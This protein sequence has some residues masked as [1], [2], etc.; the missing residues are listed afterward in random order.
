LFDVEALLEIAKQAAEAAAA[1]HRR[2]V[3]DRLSVRIK[4]SQMDLVTA[5]DREAEQ[6]LVSVIRTA[7]P[8]DGV[9][10]EEGTAVAGTSG[11]SWILDPLDGTTN[12]VYSYPAHA[13]AVGVEIDGKR[14]LGVVH[15]TYH[16]RVYTG[17]V[18]KRAE[19]NGRPIAVR[20]TSDLSCALIGTGFLPDAAVRKVQAEVLRQILPVIRDLRRS[21]S[22][23]LDLCSVAAGMLDGFYECG[24]GRWD[25]A[26]GAAIAEAAGAMV[27]E[28]QSSILPTPLLVVAN[29]KLLQA[30]IN[31]L[32]EAGAATN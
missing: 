5:V 6:Q 23:V 30:L 32:I 13:V 4:S 25:I 12:F 28:L 7:R 9:I 17:I 19:C 22:P 8:D 16:Q 11:V 24:L 10:G 31:V 21:G 2:A 3:P 14:V 29:P 1:V 26:A 27:V 20:V 15:D 18:G